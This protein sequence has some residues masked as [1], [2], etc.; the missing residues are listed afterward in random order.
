MCPGMNVVSFLC[1][2]AEAD[3]L[4]TILVPVSTASDSL[5]N[6]LLRPAPKSSRR[7]S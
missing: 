3:A 4:R 7:F 5:V 1:P 6:D 2:S